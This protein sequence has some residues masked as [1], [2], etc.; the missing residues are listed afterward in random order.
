[1]CIDVPVG[2][3][4]NTSQGIVP[5]KKRGKESE[6]TTSNDALLLRTCAIVLQVSNTE[7]EESD[8]EGEEEREEGY[9][10][11]KRTDEQEEREDEPAHQVQAE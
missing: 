6:H 9:S 4:C 2:A 1:M 8:V 5:R 7:H 11:A 10:R 3:V